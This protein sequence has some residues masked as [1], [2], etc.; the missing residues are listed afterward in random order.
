MSWGGLNILLELSKILSNDW[1]TSAKKRGRDVSCL[2]YYHKI[3][4]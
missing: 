3:V 1:E 4:F 2:G